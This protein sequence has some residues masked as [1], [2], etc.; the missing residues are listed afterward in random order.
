MKICQ[1]NPICLAFTLLS[2][3]ISIPIYHWFYIMSKTKLWLFNAFYSIHTI[4]SKSYTKTSSG[5]VCRVLSKYRWIL[6]FEVLFI[7]K[8]QPF[9]FQCIFYQLSFSIVTEE[10]PKS[11]N[12]PNFEINNFEIKKIPEQLML[13]IINLHSIQKT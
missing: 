4:K 13:A 7:P 10:I 12:I 8:S 6:H 3:M 5:C 9:H 2:G 1:S 11:E